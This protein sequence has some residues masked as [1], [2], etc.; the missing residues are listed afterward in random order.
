M[1][2]KGIF[3]L[4]IKIETR[5]KKMK[6]TLPAPMSNQT[7]HWP[8]PVKP[9]KH[10]LPPKGIYQLQTLIQYQQMGNIILPAY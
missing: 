2:Y 7:R 5:T 1:Y 4:Y 6:K 9:W 8:I 10:F 3:W